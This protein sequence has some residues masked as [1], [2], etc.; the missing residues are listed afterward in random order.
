MKINYRYRYKEI[1]IFFLFIILSIFT[2]RYI[3]NNYLLFDILEEKIFWNFNYWGLSHIISFFIL[4]LI[5]PNY[6]IFLFIM[7]ILWEIFEYFLQEIY[8]KYFDDYWYAQYI[9]LLYNGIGILLAKIIL[10]IIK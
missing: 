1:I 10:Y 6:W 2:Y 7:G 5:Y 3:K 8:K 4:T 9:D